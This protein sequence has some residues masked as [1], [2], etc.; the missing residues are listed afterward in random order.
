MAVTPRR[1]LPANAIAA[2][3]A[4][5]TVSGQA[6]ANQGQLLLV[7]GNVTVHR[8]SSTPAPD[9]RSADNAKPPAEII[10]P[11][12][13]HEVRSGDTIITG[14][15][16]RVQIRFSDGSLVS[17]QPRT[18]FRIDRYRYDTTEQRGF[19]SLA[20]G[21][22]RTVSGMVGKRNPADYRLTTPAATIGIR[23]TQFVV[24]QTVC[25]PGCYPG[26]SAGLRVA[27]TEGHVVVG[28]RAGFIEL[29]A[30]Q[31]AFTASAS[32]APVPT[33][34]RPQMTT[35]TTI[36]RPAGVGTT[37]AASNGASGSVSDNTAGTTSATAP[38][39]G[40]AAVEDAAHSNS[41]SDRLLS[42]LAGGGT[43]A[44]KVTI[45]GDTATNGEGRQVDTGEGNTIRR[46]AE[47][48]A[49]LART[50][51]PGLGVS[52]VAAVGEART[53]A[54]E[55]LAL[56]D[57][58]PPLTGVGGG[59][60]SGG[61]NTGG[62]N[63]GGGNTD[64]GNTGGGNT[65]GGNTGGGNTGGGNT[66]GGN[67]DGGNTATPHPKLNVGKNTADT[68]AF[69]APS[70]WALS[71]LA[72]VTDNP[73]FDSQMQLQSIGDC[74][75][76][77][78][79]SRGTARVADAGGNDYLRWGR[80]IDG[81]SYLTVMG[82]QTRR[83][84]SVNGGQHYLVGTPTVTMPTQGE[85]RYSLDGATAAT[86][87]NGLQAPGTF[88]GEAHVRFG[89][90]T[91]TRVGVDASVNFS[92]GASYRMQTQGGLA[93]V[94]QSELRMT[95]RTGFAGNVGVQSSAVDPVGCRS[96]GCRANISGG[97]FGPNAQSMGMQYS[98][99]RATGSAGAGSVVPQTGTTIQGIGAFSRTDDKP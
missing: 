11:S 19:F 3:L 50:A 79:L 77:L 90:G 28:N 23:G 4:T 1:R 33:D 52:T 29:P 85:A 83:T 35:A 24:E 2:A 91:A 62:S 25:N 13:G 45:D 51:Q 8:E 96:G 17:L 76:T 82:I 12:A 78:C 99:G 55:R 21:A 95:G 30:G 5:L 36:I 54:G 73:T 72:P 14:Y 16:G 53:P 74:P 43:S 88:A 58:K 69:L 20:A 18:E 31:A 59:N 64:G 86:Y 57:M 42:R 87:S 70:A 81:V 56:N 68:S 65:G 44:G 97:F 26:N 71:W 34:D 80:W 7:V 37:K 41:D 46:V 84:L 39:Q 6:L 9:G 89:T 66:G 40:S 93:D 15:D 38:S 49:E 47:I 63:T 60:A 48:E 22:I 75:S 32:T 10:I 27:V 94:S 92:D 67:T 61:G 98:L